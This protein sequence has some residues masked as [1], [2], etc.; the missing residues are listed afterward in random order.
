MPIN[1]ISSIGLILCSC[2]HW[3]G[4]TQVPV[5]VAYLLGV[6]TRAFIF[7]NYINWWIVSIVY[8]VFTC[9]GGSCEYDCPQELRTVAK[10]IIFFLIILIG[11]LQFQILPR[12][13][14]ASAFDR[15]KIRMIIHMIFIHFYLINLLINIFIKSTI[16][17]FL[18]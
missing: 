17:I 14:L 10:S 9:V 12:D 13:I 2:E 5:A 1:I 18:F 6:L 7:R 11:I 3:V 4:G 8:A 16:I 15:F